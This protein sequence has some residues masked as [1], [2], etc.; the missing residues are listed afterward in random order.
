MQFHEKCFID[1]RISI[2]WSIKFNS[3]TSLFKKGFLV[4]NN[5]INK[6]GNVISRSTFIS[7]EPFKSN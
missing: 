4:S 5:A 3:P 6:L 2:I 7:V 1:D